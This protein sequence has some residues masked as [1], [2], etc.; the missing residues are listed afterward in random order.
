M[1]RGWHTKRGEKEVGRDD[2]EGMREL[3]EQIQNTMVYSKML[4]VKR[5]ILKIRAK[6]DTIAC[7]GSTRNKN[8]TKMKSNEFWVELNFPE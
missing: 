7:V 3:G 8:D 6:Y 2:L 4:T 5:T 1:S